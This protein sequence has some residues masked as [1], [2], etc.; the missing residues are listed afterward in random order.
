MDVVADNDGFLTG[1]KGERKKKT[2]KE[3]PKVRKLEDWQ[4]SRQIA[5]A[6]RGNA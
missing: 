1:R 6:R 4:R 5:K 2:G 3:R